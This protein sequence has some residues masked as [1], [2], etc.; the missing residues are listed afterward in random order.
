MQWL[1]QI[2]SKKGMLTAMLISLQNTKKRNPFQHSI[3]T[4]VSRM[5]WV[6]HKGKQT[7]S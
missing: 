1:K 7:T 3:K 4:D 2:K 6:K 5:K